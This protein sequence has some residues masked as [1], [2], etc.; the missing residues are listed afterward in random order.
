MLGCLLVERYT[1][2]FGW[3]VSDG[4]VEEDSSRRCNKLRCCVFV[5]YL[6]RM[7]E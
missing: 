5:L 2:N 1:Q 4:E 6:D 7:M 3:R